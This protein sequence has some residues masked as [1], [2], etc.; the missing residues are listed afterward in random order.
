MS[1]FAA[2]RHIVITG[3]SSGIGAA[4]ARHYA[5][6]ATV[7]GLVGRDEG[8]LGAITE[9]CR[10]LGAAVVAGRLEVREAEELAAWLVEFDSL[11]PVDLVIAN[12]GVASGASAKGGIEPPDRVREVFEVNLLGAANTILPLIEPMRARGHGQIALMASLAA[13]WP[14]PNTPSYSASKAALLAYG[15]ALRPRLGAAGVGVTVVCPGFVKT[16]MTAR[17][18]GPTPG[19]MADDRAAELI[20][21]GLGRDPAV[22]AFPFWPALGIRAMGL[23]PRWV[24]GRIWRIFDYSAKPEQS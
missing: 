1:P 9:Q 10:R 17:L 13:F 11:H 22:L 19:L 18:S 8:R 7:L 20:A 2:P 23:L 16:P 15:L 24:S 3:A 4:L 5:G 14:A 21:R 6:P 12:A